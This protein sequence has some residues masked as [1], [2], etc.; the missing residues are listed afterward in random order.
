MCLYSKL[1]D[2]PKYKK[3]KK[4]GGNPPICKD[5]RTLYVPVGCGRCI[6]CKKAKQREWSVRLREEIKHTKGGKFITLTFTDESIAELSKEIK[7]EK[8]YAFD[9]AIATIA[10]RRW[11]ERYRKKHKTSVRHWLVTE[12]G[13]NGTENIHLHGIVWFKNEEEFIKSDELWKYGMVLKGH[14]KKQGKI[15]KYENYVNEETIG[16]ITKYVS[17][18]DYDHKEYNAIILTSAGIGRNYIN[19]QD[20]KRNKYNEKNT[21]EYYTTETGHK[22]SLPIYY[23]NKI[24][25]EEE[26]E[27]LWRNKMDEETRYV[28]GAKVDI[29]KGMDD[30]ENTLQCAREK[31]IR[32]GYQTNEIDRDRLIYEQ[33]IRIIMNETRKQKGYAKRLKARIGLR[34][35]PPGAP[36]SRGAAD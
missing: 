24:Y 17:K 26:R 1:I 31:N 14:E 4:N 30:Y 34:P 20:A 12:L 27:Q 8:G 5:P 33:R 35:G 3:N 32:L 16:Y 2:N 22:V 23:R 15:T 28:L 10:V 36:G 6:E 11:L 25:T 19:R 9:N 7:A 29:S 18:M 21:K 13:H